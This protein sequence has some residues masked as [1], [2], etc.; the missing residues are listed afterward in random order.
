MSTLHIK[1][2]STSVVLVLLF[3]VCN[4]IAAED[5]DEWSMIPGFMKDKLAKAGASEKQIAEVNKA[6]A[7]LSSP[8]TLKKIHELRAK[9]KDLD[10]TSAE[11]KKLE[12]QYKKLNVPVIK[13]LKIIISA[14]LDK[15]QLEK[16]IELSM[17]PKLKK[18]TLPDSYKRIFKQMGKE[19]TDAM[20]VAIKKAYESNLPL[21]TQIKIRAMS[22]KKSYYA[23]DSPGAKELLKKIEELKRP[24]VREFR[25][26]LKDEIFNA[27]QW[28]QFLKIEE[29]NRAR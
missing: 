23:K 17:P 15:T 3:L 13:K 12:S 9:K 8:A 1:F 20:E 4:V 10:K 2:I 24:L 6:Y 27:S 28:S 16:Y 7:K 21:D 25:M 11:F 5:S 14:T 22:Y 26:I 19:I 18:S 29:A